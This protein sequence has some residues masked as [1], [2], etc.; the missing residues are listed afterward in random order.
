[1]TGCSRRNRKTGK[2][3]KAASHCV[4]TLIAGACFGSMPIDCPEP[5]TLR[6]VSSTC[7]VFRY[8]PGAST[9]LPTSIADAINKYLIQSSAWRLER[10]NQRH[11]TEKSFNQQLWSHDLQPSELELQAMLNLVPEKIPTKGMLMEYEKSQRN[12]RRG[13]S[14]HLPLH[15]HAMA[16]L[17]TDLSCS[18][19]HRSRRNSFSQDKQLNTSGKLP[20]LATFPKT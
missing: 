2:H 3:T 13:R 16:G 1:V 15:A 5:F 6:A 18:G 12:K 4:G 20:E 17:N 19:L 7:E 14:Q 8:A 9:N 11:L 10:Q